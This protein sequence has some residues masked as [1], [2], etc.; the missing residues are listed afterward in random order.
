MKHPV[1]YTN[2]PDV[3]DTPL[4]FNSFEVKGHHLLADGEALHELA[5]YRRPSTLDDGGAY[6]AVLV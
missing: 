3:A 2:L 6:D 1:Y 5:G 4:H